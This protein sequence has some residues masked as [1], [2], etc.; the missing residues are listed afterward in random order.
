[1]PRTEFK[2]SVSVVHPEN[3]EDRSASAY[4]A[5]LHACGQVKLGGRLIRR[6]ALAASSKSNSGET[7]VDWKLAIL[8]R[9]SPAQPEVTAYP[10][11]AS[12]QWIPS[13]KALHCR[14]L[15]VLQS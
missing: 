10:N 7:M 14:T 13:R 3:L 1:M 5:A 2:K 4:L 11:W 6:A 8:P 9:T 12:I 15:G